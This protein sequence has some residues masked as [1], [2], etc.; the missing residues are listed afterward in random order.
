MNG[1][2]SGSFGSPRIL[3]NWVQFE[4][5][6]G[7]LTGPPGAKPTNAAIDVLTPS[8]GLFAGGPPSTKTRGEGSVGF[9]PF[10]WGSGGAPIPP[11]TPPT[12]GGEPGRDVLEPGGR[13]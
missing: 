11:G 8:I 1:P 9:S 10:P 4:I 5:R 6:I 13:T 2:L 3:A 12:T 7:V